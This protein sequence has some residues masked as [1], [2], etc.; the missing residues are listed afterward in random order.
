LLG[1]FFLLT[2]D[3]KMMTTNKLEIKDTVIGTGREAVAG[4]EISVHYTGWLFDEESE[5]SKGIKF[6]SSKDRQSP[7]NFPLGVGMVIRGWDEGFAGM[8]EGGKRTLIIPSEMAY[9]ASGAGPD[10]PPHATLIFD[11]ELIKVYE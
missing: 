11:I 10:I 8:K 5:N 3:L 7:F 9:G 4:K 2:K 1:Y 6:D